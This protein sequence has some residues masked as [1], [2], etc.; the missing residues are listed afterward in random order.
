MTLPATWLPS[1]SSS[2]DMGACLMGKGL[3]QIL[4]LLPPTPW[5][6]SPYSSLSLSFLVYEP[7]D[8]K[9]TQML[10]VCN[11]PAPLLGWP[12]DSALVLGFSI[13]TTG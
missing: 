13:C 12:R 9:G 7:E 10:R 5:T 6:A 8:G 2:P 1:A 3:R 4:A 11:P